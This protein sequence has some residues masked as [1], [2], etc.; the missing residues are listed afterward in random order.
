MK[1]SFPTKKKRAYF[2]VLLFIIFFFLKKQPYTVEAATSA[3]QHPAKTLYGED[4]PNNFSAKDCHWEE[5]SLF[6]SH[7]TPKD[8]LLQTSRTEFG[9]EILMSEGPEGRGAASQG[10]MALMGY[11]GGDASKG[12]PL[13]HPGAELRVD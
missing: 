10:V 7:P 11:S 4:L 6:A 5:Q 13:I 8:L 12:A 9:S 2:I 1:S 3:T